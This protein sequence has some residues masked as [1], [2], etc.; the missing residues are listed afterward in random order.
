MHDKWK[1]WS[2][3]LSR[4][5]D[6][7]FRKDNVRKCRTCNEYPVEGTLALGTAAGSVKQPEALYTGSSPSSGRIVKVVVALAPI[8]LFQFSVKTLIPQGIASHTIQIS[9]DADDGYYNEQDG[10][11]WHST[12]QGGGADLV[13]SW[14][15]T[16]TAWVAGY[17][18][19]ST[20]INSGDAI[21]TA[22]LQL[23]SS[24]GD[25]TSTVCGSAPCASSSSTFRVYGVAQDDGAA[26][27]NTSGNTPVSVPYT[28]AYVDY[29]TT[30][31][32]DAHGSCQGKTMDRTPAPISSM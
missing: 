6:F 2:G 32:G 7:K 10:T 26:F 24:D 22:Y 27:S 3:T 14:G 23:V 13:G 29:T 21:R 11:G 18:F 4:F 19:P 28:T 17:R 16:T 8:L 25:A 15:G 31:P 30:G 1:I 20:G 9:S 5:A 12:P